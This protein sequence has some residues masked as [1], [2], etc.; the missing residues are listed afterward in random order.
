MSPLNDYQEYKL[1]LDK[2]DIGF[3]I[4]WND[5][6]SHTFEKLNL[7]RYIDISFAQLDLHYELNQDGV[8]V[9]KRAAKPINLQQ[10][11]VGRFGG[12]NKSMSLL[13]MNQLGWYCPQNLDINLI[14]QGA[15]IEKNSIRFQIK[16]CKNETLINKNY[17]CVSNEEIFNFT[18]S[19]TVAVATLKTFFDQDDFEEPLK[20]DITLDYFGIKVGTAFNQLVSVKRNHLHSKNSMFSS[21]FENLKYQFYDVKLDRNYLG[22]IHPNI[23]EFFNLFVTCSNEEVYIERAR[24]TIVDIMSIVGGFASIIILLTKYSLKLY[25]RA[26]Y[27]SKLINRLFVTQGK[28]KGNSDQYQITEKNKDNVKS[29]LNVILNTIKNRERLDVKLYAHKLSNIFFCFT[30]K[31]QIGVSNSHIQK[32]LKKQIIENSIRK[33]QKSFDIIRIQ[34]QLMNLKSFQKLMLKPYQ[35]TLLQYMSPCIVKTNHEKNKKKIKRQEV[36]IMKEVVS[37]A[38]NKNNPIDIAILN[39]IQGEIDIHKRSLTIRKS[40]TDQSLDFDKYSESQNK[41]DFGIGYH[42]LSLRHIKKQNQ[43]N[44]LILKPIKID[45]SVIQAFDICDMQSIESSPIM[46]FKKQLAKKS[47]SKKKSMWTP[48]TLLMDEGKSYL[49]AIDQSTTRQL[50]EDESSS[51]KNTSSKR[52]KVKLQS[53][54]IK[55]GKL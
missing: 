13:G 36:D 46:K 4:F 16:Q 24:V 23:W 21:F 44:Q 41:Q 9:L 50:K 14:G 38:V 27:E 22:D 28:R 7:H 1:S 34:K 19:I 53:P 30:K 37:K 42:S 54:Q 49:S 17:T 39:D 48:Q 3:G 6:Q 47:I 26:L 11:E 5:G 18:S 35:S 10:C 40:G 29:I 51:R 8:K 52:K 43:I 33:Y 2:F 12:L 31:V 55:E 45:D 25:Q 15:S 20:K 32:P